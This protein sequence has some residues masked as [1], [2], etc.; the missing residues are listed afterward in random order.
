MPAAPGA[1]KT[2][3]APFGMLP[4]SQME[5]GKDLRSHIHDEDFLY[6]AIL[7]LFDFLPSDTV[8]ALTLLYV[9][10]SKRFN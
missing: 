9:N 1:D 8:Q 2:E 4:E 5:E 10:L 3:F 6:F 7:R